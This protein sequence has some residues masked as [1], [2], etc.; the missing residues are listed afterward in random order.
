GT[1]QVVVTAA[2]PAGLV[3][4]AGLAWPG[5]IVIGAG[6]AMFSTPVVLPPLGGRGLVN[7]PAGRDAFA[8]L[9]FQDLAFIPLVALV[10]L[11]AS[12]NV[13]DQVPWHDVA[14]AAFAIAVVLV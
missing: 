5:A 13:P 11:L 1:A 14:R 6:L 4:L 8:V 12:D 7:S 3:H 10:P 2:A 9:L